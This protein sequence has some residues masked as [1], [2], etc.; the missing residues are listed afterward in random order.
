MKKIFDKIKEELKEGH[1]LVLASI[2]AQKGSSPRGLGTQMLVGTEGRLCGTVGGG[3]V[4]F[5]SVQYAKELL[6]EKRS[7]EMFFSMNPKEE[8]NIGM[9]CGGDVTIWFQFID[10]WR[11]Q[12]K[13]LTDR[14]LKQMEERRAGWLVLDLSGNM[15]VLLEDCGEK[16][17]GF[18]ASGEFCRKD[19]QVFIPIL[20]QDRVV[21]FGGGHCAQA[22]VP[23]LSTV[24]FRVTVMDNREE[25]CQKELFPEAEAVVCGDFRDLS[26]SITWSESDF[27]V[28]MTNGHSFDYEVERQVLQNPPCYVGA[29]GSRHKKEFVNKKLREAGVSETLINQVHCPIGTEI[30]AVTPE[31][32]AIS[33]AGEMILE[34]SRLRNGEKDVPHRCP[35][36]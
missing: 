10:G 34:R 35:M 7:C 30:Q 13:E 33:I 1:D 9:V 18:P 21:I 26:A 3:A 5:Q 36:H 8:E 22:L 19:S 2:I 29:I 20:I 27:L 4:E 14:L 12:W 23:I 11:S 28:I 32:I 25:L 24:G 17:E 6:T 15:P 16:K 31:E